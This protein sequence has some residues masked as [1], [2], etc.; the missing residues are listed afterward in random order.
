MLLGPPFRLLRL[1][2]LGFDSWFGFRLGFGL[3]FGSFLLR[4]GLLGRFCD[5]CS[6]GFPCSGG[7]S[8]CMGLGARYGSSC[9]CSGGDWGYKAGLERK[10]GYVV[11]LEDTVE[12]CYAFD[13]KDVGCRAMTP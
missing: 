10:V 7:R 6:R 11:R 9:I 12:G 2:R 4:S 1:L 13:I 8:S 5:R 3:R